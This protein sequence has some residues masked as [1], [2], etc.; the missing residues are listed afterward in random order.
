[1][2]QGV[3]ASRRTQTHRQRASAACATPQPM[4]QRRPWHA[5]GHFK[6]LPCPRSALRLLR[7][8]LTLSAGG[9]AAALATT[10]GARALARARPPPC[11]PLAEGSV[12]LSA[13]A[14]GVAADCL[15]VD[16]NRRHLAEVG[17]SKREEEDSTE[18]GEQ[19]ADAVSRLRA[20]RSIPRRA[21]ARAAGRGGHRG[22]ARHRAA[23]P[24]RHQP[25]PNGRPC[26]KNN[27]IVPI[28]RGD[29]PLDV[30]NVLC[31]PTCETQIQ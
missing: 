21:V 23:S 10:D 22:G 8:G 12:F 6:M 2:S 31:T 1:M 16:P 9:R 20:G 4:G 19:L 15:G 28:L 5:F 25:V 7:P 30:L 13:W 17:H 29:R 3:T 26:P 18:R 27:S 11:W 24:S 14:V